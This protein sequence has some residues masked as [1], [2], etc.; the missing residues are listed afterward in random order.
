MA[1]TSSTQFTCTRLRTTAGMSISHFCGQVP[2]PSS[3]ATQ[4]LV[5]LPSLSS[6]HGGRSPR[7]ASQSHHR[8]PSRWDQTTRAAGSRLISHPRGLLVHGERV[9]R[10]NNQKSQQECLKE[11]S[12][13][14]RVCAARRYMRALVHPSARR[15]RSKGDGTCW[16]FTLRSCAIMPS[17]RAIPPHLS[18][19]VNL[20][21]TYSDTARWSIPRN[22]GH[23]K[24]RRRCINS[25]HYWVP[26]VA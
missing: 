12:N 11:G 14:S 21:R 6:A 18:T 15:A 7:R 2:T 24:R 4:G 17:R 20:S 22:V 19:S 26:C 23:A 13:I 16:S 3:K 25:K 8:P 5:P 10:E 9:A 1:E